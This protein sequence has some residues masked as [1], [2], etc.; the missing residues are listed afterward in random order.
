ML[1]KLGNQANI[2]HSFVFLLSYYIFSEIQL[3]IFSSL[4]FFLLNLFAFLESTKDSCMWLMSSEP[5]TV[6]QSQYSGVGLKYN[7]PDGNWD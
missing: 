2:Y 4:H 5:S 7:P 6:S 1:F 3:L